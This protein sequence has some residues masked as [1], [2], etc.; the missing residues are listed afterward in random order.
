LI[1]DFA[2]ARPQSVNACL[3][4]L[5]TWCRV[6]RA[7]QKVQRQCQR[8]Q[9]SLSSSFSRDIGRC[10][11][12]FTVPGVS[13]AVKWRISM[14]ARSSTAQ[15]LSG[16]VS[17]FLPLYQSIARGTGSSFYLATIVAVALRS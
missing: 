8:Q 1:A 11:P 2:I 14:H 7:G 6:E 4:P 10:A 15:K 5:A 17:G 16:R 3:A 13:A 9:A 12:T